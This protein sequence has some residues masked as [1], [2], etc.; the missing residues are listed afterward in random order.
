MRLNSSRKVLYLKTLSVN[1]AS[2]IN[3]GSFGDSKIQLILMFASFNFRCPALP[4]KIK[5]RRKFNANYNFGRSR[6]FENS[7]LRELKR[8]RAMAVIILLRASQ[9]FVALIM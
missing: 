2:K 5:P 8:A 7:E 6:A 4:M 3:I 9:L 1:V